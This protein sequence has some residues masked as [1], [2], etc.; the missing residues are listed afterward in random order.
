MDA[1]QLAHFHDRG[2]LK[3]A[4]FHPKARLLPFKNRLLAELKRLG[5]WGSGK[6]LPHAMRQLP[7]FQQITRLSSSIRLPDLHAQLASPEVLALVAE[8]AGRKPTSIADTQLLLS[9]PHR[10]TWSLQQL[11]WHVDVTADPSGRLPGIQAFH[12]IDDVA[13]HGG[14]TLGLAGSHLAGAITPEIRRRLSPAER[15]DP[16]ALGLPVVEMSGRAGDLYLM[17]MRLLHTPSVNAGK[18]LRMMAT[19][20]FLFV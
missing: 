6:A 5:V 20:R 15:V 12:L 19:T 11:N 8:L 18:G 3:L 7:P 13:P 2:W 14:A 16:G 1:T 10:E 4:A 17:D 9:L